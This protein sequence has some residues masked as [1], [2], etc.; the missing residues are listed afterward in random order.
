MTEHPFCRVAFVNKPLIG[1]IVQQETVDIC[2]QHSNTQ[3]EIRSLA[4]IF[5]IQTRHFLRNCCKVVGQ[6][7]ALIKFKSR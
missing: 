4:A 1:D 5:T 2:G 6:N 7:I 3:Y